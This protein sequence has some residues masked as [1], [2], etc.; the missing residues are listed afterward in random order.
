M[1]SVMSDVPTNCNESL[2]D[3][4]VV[5]VA[6]SAVLNVNPLYILYVR[7][8]T[9][10][11][12]F[13]TGSGNID[14]LKLGWNRSVPPVAEVPPV[15]ITNPAVKLPA[16]RLVSPTVVMFPNEVIPAD[17]LPRL[18]SNIYMLYV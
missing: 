6:L 5:T 8:E 9:L 11:T 13:P 18:I 7:S 10:F 17:V 12:E 15:P 16:P 1:S 3:E 4:S 2:P 14:V